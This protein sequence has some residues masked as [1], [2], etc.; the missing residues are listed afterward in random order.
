[1]IFCEGEIASK[2]P[3]HLEQLEQLGVVVVVDELERNSS[4]VE[5][6]QL[7]EQMV[8]QFEVNNQMVDLMLVAKSYQLL[9]KFS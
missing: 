2:L 6:H 9:I 5:Q 7:M 8:E 3:E 4:F 1:M